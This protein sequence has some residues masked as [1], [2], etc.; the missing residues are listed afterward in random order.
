MH[1]ALTA[2]C[3]CCVTGNQLRHTVRSWRD[4][5]SIPSPSWRSTKRAARPVCCCRQ[6]SNI[7]ETEHA[8][9]SHSLDDPTQDSV[10]IGSPINFTN[11][12][13]FC[14]RRWQ[15]IT[16]GIVTFEKCQFLELF[17]PPLMYTFLTRVNESVICDLCYR[18]YIQSLLLVK[19]TLQ[20]TNYEFKLQIKATI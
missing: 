19:F 1:L 20:I 9:V 11:K 12:K 6:P 3:Y 5:E 7:L 8:P 10:H 15:Y 17:S 13:I 16:L 18:N 4:R 14:E 2:H